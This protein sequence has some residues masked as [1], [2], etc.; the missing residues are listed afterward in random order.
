[1]TPRKR[2]ENLLFHVEEKYFRE[3]LNGTKEEEYRLRV[4]YW[5]SRLERQ[6]PPKF[7]VVQS[8]FPARGEPGRTL[9]FPYRGYSVKTITHPHFGGGPVSVFAIRLEGGILT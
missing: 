2:S 7:V 5:A 3:M 6:P 9:T 1:M 4:P 8:G